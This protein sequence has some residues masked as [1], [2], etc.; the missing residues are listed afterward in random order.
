MCPDSAQP[1]PNETRFKYMI[2]T[3]CLVRQSTAQPKETAQDTRYIYPH[4]VAAQ[5][6]IIFTTPARLLPNNS[7]LNHRTGSASMNSR[8]SHR[9]EDRQNNCD[10]EYEKRDR[11]T[12]RG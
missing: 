5:P 6:S 1:A 8:R 4:I 3:V 2:A 9:R 10:K 7:N 11:D 12:G